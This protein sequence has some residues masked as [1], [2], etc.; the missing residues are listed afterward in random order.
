MQA[1]FPHFPKSNF[2]IQTIQNIHKFD[3]MQ[4]KAQSLIK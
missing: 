2:Y 4:T 3:H 1:K